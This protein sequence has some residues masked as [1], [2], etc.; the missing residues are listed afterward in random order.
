MTACGNPTT[1]IFE[2]PRLGG[3]GKPE[4]SVSSVSVVVPTYNRAELLRLTVQSI[5]RQTVAP[6]E[7]IIV[8]DGSTDHTAQVCA[9]FGD[10]IQ[11][12]RQEN[13]RLPAAR[14]TGIRAARGAWISLCDSD[15]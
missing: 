2:A 15:D 11:Y 14:N 9:A 3:R 8:D 6:L 12:L 7:V 10:S 4:S 1:A 13:Q 5:L